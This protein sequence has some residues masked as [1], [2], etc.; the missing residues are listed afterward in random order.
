[1]SAYAWASESAAAFAAFADSASLS[2]DLDRSTL[3]IAWVFFAIAWF[4]MSFSACVVAIESCALASA[5]AVTYG[6]MSKSRCN[7]AAPA[8]SPFAVSN[9]MRLLVT[10]SA[11]LDRLPYAAIKP[12]LACVCR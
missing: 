7:D 9:P 5:I 1:M 11:V 12:L 4:S 10:M 8:V 2:K 3:A 6:L